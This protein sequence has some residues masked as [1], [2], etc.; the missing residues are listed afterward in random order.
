VIKVF[1]SGSLT[2][3]LLES[4]VNRFL[5]GLKAQKITYKLHVTATG[6]SGRFTTIVVEYEI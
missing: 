6:H 4:E 2:K 3:G 5:Q 1:D